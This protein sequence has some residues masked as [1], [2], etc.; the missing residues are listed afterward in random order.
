M[1]K[2]AI[3][4][5]ESISPFVGEEIIELL[6]HPKRAIEVNI[7][8][9]GRI[10]KAYRVHYNNALGP[11]KGGIRFH[12][13]VNMEE[14]KALAF[15]MSIK[16]SLLGL[17]F[18]GG[19]GGMA[20]N[21]K[22]LTNE[23]LEQISREFVRQFAKDIGPNLDIP[24]PDVYTNAQV[25]AWMMDEYNKI[26]QTHSPGVVT[27]KPIILGGSKAREY[28]TSQGAYYVLNAAIE[29]YDFSRA[30]LHTAIHGFGNAGQHFAKIL[31][32]DGHKVIAVSD[33][34]GAVYNP[35]GFDIEKLIEYKNKNGELSGYRN[36]KEIS[37]E[38]LL[39]LDADVLGL[40]A[41]SGT[42]TENNAG[43]VKAK[44]V[45]ELANGPVTSEAEKIMLKNNTIILPDILANAGGVTVSYFEWVQNN[46]GEIWEEKRVL[47]ALY[48]KM[49]QA[50]V[51][52]HNYEKKYDLD[53]RTA[54]YLY[55]VERLK[56]AEKLRGRL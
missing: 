52:V 39:A 36:A 17:P 44:L 47:E 50:F 34:K 27:G 48:Q 12:P 56:E 2:S 30:G 6:S 55:A 43:N 1:L 15:W 21:P 9:K 3:K 29:Q 49:A 42:I 24:A 38:E 28:A 40:A 13:E 37:H 53:L 32:K 19:K 14:T 26:T 20:I 25:M 45:V 41:L 18:G 22:E 46:T 31:E 11:A 10:I 7:P 4:K 54:A 23:E 5:L 8:F 51:N 35:N 33:S 16:N